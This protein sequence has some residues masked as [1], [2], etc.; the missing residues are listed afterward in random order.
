M[1]GVLMLGLDSTFFLLLLVDKN[2]KHF[3]AFRIAVSMS[4][5]K[6]LEDIVIFC[7]EP[8]EGGPPSG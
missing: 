1:G 3:I 4:L 6:S 8:P 7:W 2:R 5:V